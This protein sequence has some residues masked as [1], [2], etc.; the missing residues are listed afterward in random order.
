MGPTEAVAVVAGPPLLTLPAALLGVESA[1]DVRE[2]HGAPGV[3]AG[4]ETPVPKDL[5]VRVVRGP[6]RP[7][8]DAGRAP[9]PAARVVGRQVDDGGQVTW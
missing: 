1:T 9:G 6:L 5:S 2:V 3:A 4:H 8:A 7:S